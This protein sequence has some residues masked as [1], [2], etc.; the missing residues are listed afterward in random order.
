[1]HLITNGIV[2]ITA[3]DAPAVSVSRQVISGNGKVG[4]TV[5]CV[6]VIG[7]FAFS[8]LIAITPCAALGGAIVD[9]QTL[10]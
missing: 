9:V 6:F 10:A 3:L 7:G 8:Y 5:V 1:M 2:G 4:Q